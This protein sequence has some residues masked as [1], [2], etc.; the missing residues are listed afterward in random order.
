MR[1]LHNDG[2]PIQIDTRLPA[3][4]DVLRGVPGLT[5]A[6]LFGSYGTPYQTPLSDVD[7]ALLFRRGAVPGFEDELAVRGAIHDALKEDDVSITVLNHASVL[8][9]FRVVRTGR[10]LY[11]S[12][13][14][15]LADFIAPMLSRHADFR[16]DYDRFVCEYDQ[17]LRARSVHA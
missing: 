12:D 16:I 14:G 5:A 4:V 10:L 2:R 9:Q 6:Y 7:L 8:L 13:A 15:A 11:V 17:A 3:L 1:K